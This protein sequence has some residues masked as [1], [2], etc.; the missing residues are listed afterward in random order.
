MGKWRK[1][2]VPVIALFLAHEPILLLLSERI[3]RHVLQNA[4]DR[5]GTRPVFGRIGPQLSKT[6]DSR[7]RFGL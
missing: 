4:Q 5:S 2:S 1:I 3:S 7:F 6:R